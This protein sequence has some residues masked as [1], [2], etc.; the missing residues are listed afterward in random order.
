MVT[1]RNLYLVAVPSTSYGTF[2]GT[3]SLSRQAV[4][5]NGKFRVMVKED[6]SLTDRGPYPQYRHRSRGIS[7]FEKKSGVYYE[8]WRNING[9]PPDF[10]SVSTPQKVEM[11]YFIGITMMLGLGGLK[12]KQIVL[13]YNDFYAAAGCLSPFKPKKQ[14]LWF[15]RPKQV[16][17]SEGGFDPVW[18]LKIRPKL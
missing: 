6:T 3:V 12:H 11:R 8:L 18:V 1:H 5:A 13:A 9:F 14:T 7:L 17:K 10:Y 4:D 2:R 15:L 16:L